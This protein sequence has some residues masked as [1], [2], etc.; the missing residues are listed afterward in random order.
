[1]PDLHGALLIACRELALTVIATGHTARARS[2]WLA[3]H[4]Y[5]TALTQQEWRGFAPGSIRTVTDPESGRR[6]QQAA[7]TGLAFTE[8]LDGNMLECARYLERADEFALQ[9]T[10]SPGSTC[11]LGEIARAHLSVELQRPDQLTA[12]QARLEPLQDR[13]G[14]WPALLIAEAEAAHLHRGVDWASAQ[15]EAGMAH[16]RLPLNGAASWDGWLATYRVQ[17]NTT[18]GRLTQ[19]ESLLE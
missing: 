17:L 7:L 2:A 5:A 12:A 8:L 3:L 18:A 11:V 1:S 6:W 13:V 19:A 16:A 10:L 9:G 4:A 14:P 15:L